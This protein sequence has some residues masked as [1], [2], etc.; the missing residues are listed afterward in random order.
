M[1]SIWVADHMFLGRD[2]AIFESWTALC[3]LAG[4]TSS[5]RLGDIHLGNGFRPPGLT[6]KMVASLDYISG[7]RFDFFID[8][9]WRER[10]HTAFGFEWEPDRS[11]RAAQVAETIELCRASWSG[12]STTFTGRVHPTLRCDQYAAPCTPGGPAVWIG[13]SFD[14]ATLDLVVAHADVWNS[15]PRDSRSCRRRSRS[16]TMRVVD[17]AGTREPLRRL[18]RPRC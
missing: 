14:E 1:D 16:W 18:S 3:V 2:G 8:P 6:A 15:M 17:A 9:G 5:I 13:E 12:E 4:A 10:E 7:G 11:L